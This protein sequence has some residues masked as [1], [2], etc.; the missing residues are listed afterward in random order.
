DRSSSSASSRGESL[1]PSSA[2]APLRN[3]SAIVLCGV[4]SRARLLNLLRQ[5]FG[6]VF[7]VQRTNQLVE[8]AVHDIVQLVEREI[9]AMVGHAALR[10]VIGANALGTIARTHLQLARLSLLTLL[11]FALGGEQPGPQQGHGSRTVFVLRALVLAFH[12]HAGG[13]VGDADRRIG[14]V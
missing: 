7:L 14:L 8:I 12:H 5:L 4:K 6:L 10:K 1:R 3:I 11:L 2:R 13:N 9:D